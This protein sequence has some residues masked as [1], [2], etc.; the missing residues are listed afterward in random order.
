MIEDTVVETAAVRKDD[1]PRMVD[2]KEYL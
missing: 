1:L 2:L